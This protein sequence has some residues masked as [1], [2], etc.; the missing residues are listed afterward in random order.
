MLYQ[1]LILSRLLVLVLYLQLAFCLLLDDNS[2]NTFSASSSCDLNQGFWYQ[3]T[4]WIPIQCH[5]SYQRYFTNYIETG[6]WNSELFGNSFNGILYGD[7]NAGLIIAD[8]MNAIMKLACPYKN[9]RTFSCQLPHFTLLKQQ[10]YSV[11]PY[12]SN[13]YD[14]CHEF[15]FLTEKEKLYFKTPEE[16]YDFGMKQFHLLIQNK[17]TT[18]TITITDEKIIMPDIVDLSVNFWE[19]VRLLEATRC[20]KNLTSRAEHKAMWRSSELSL[21]FVHRWTQQYI[22]LLKMWKAKTSEYGAVL[23][24]R[25]AQIPLLDENGTAIHGLLGKNTF[26]HQLNAGIR[27]AAKEV[28]VNLID[29]E[30]M[31]NYFHNSRIYLRDKLHVKN[32]INVEIMNRL[33][34][35]VA[36]KRIHPKLSK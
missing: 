24:T 16:I 14:Y 11:F 2:N 31:T 7:S 9:S 6:K 22:T 28:G 3:N 12:H 26:V 30:L 5:D 1:Q 18:T 10:I 21:E 4:T 23:Y 27:I 15:S 25:T 32:F 17:T 36:E 33:M 13:D 20:G 35:F 34:Y 29:V 8:S 19:M